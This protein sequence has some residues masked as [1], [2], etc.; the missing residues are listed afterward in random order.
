[1]A[2][3]ELFTPPPPPNPLRPLPLPTI[4][5]NF[6]YHDNFHIQ[7]YPIEIKS[8]ALPTRRYQVTDPIWLRRHGHLAKFTY[9]RHLIVSFWYTWTLNL[10]TELEHLFGLVMGI[11]SQLQLTKVQTMAQ[12]NLPVM[13]LKHSKK[14]WFLV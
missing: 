5:T 11:F 2:P 14:V 9:S 7:N 12:A 10:N 8:T 4:A 1:M 3:D 13:Q 6:K